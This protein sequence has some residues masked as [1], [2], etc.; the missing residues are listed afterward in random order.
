GQYVL[1][2]ALAM[3]AVVT[4]LVV[5]ALVVIGPLLGDGRE[6]A[7]RFGLGTAFEVAWSVARWPVLGVVSATYLTILYRYGPNVRTTWRHCL[8]GAVVG[9]IGLVLVAGGFAVYLDLA[10]PTA[11][12]AGT[13]E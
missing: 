10:G 1:G 5:L 7:D 3:G 6:I 9:T 8:P 13:M 2:I 4:L 11:P 12:G